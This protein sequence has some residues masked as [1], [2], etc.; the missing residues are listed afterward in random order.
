MDSVFCRQ[1]FGAPAK[2]ASC[3]I[4]SVE[5]DDSPLCDRYK[6]PSVLWISLS[7]F[8]SP[9]KRSNW[10]CT[11]FVFCF[12]FLLL[13]IKPTPM[14]VHKRHF[15]Q[16]SRVKPIVLGREK[17]S[18]SANVP[19]DV[20]PR[21][22]SPSRICCLHVRAGGSLRTREPLNRASLDFHTACTC[23]GNAGN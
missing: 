21:W 23:S 12:F 2:T 18:T 7:I 11:R 9:I 4:I 19:S 17:A 5:E 8:F 15:Q 3:Y 6:E 22:F 10:K 14:P 16:Y 1:I 20:F 13:L